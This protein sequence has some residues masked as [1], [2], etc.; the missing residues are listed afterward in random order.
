MV[1]HQSTEGYNIFLD[2]QSWVKRDSDDDTD[3]EDGSLQEVRD[4]IE[5][6]CVN[7]RDP[8]E[9]TGVNI[10]FMQDEN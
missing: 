3:A 10:P 1:G 5:L 8:L 6:L 4:A 9:A 2:T 7:F